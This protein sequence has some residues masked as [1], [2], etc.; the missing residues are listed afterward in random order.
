MLPER[1]PSSAT[2]QTGASGRSF[3]V[4]RWKIKHGAVDV[5]GIGDQAILAQ[6]CLSLICSVQCPGSVVI[7]TF[8]AIRELR[9]AGITVAGGFH[10]PM[11]K[12]CLEF[13]LRGE[14]PVI[15]VQAKGLGRLR[16]P[17]PWRAP[18]DAGRLL[19]LAPFDDD[20]GR[21]T[22]AHAQTRN[23]VITAL[24]AAVLIPHASPGGKA[25]TVARSVLQRGQA[26]FTFDD[27]ENKGL[28]QLGAHPYNVDEIKYLITAA[29]LPNPVAL[30]R[31]HHENS[32]THSARS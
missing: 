7:K 28:F 23:E 2:V 3:G 1:T 12:E 17:E 21:T 18:I 5:H 9:D 32:S 30:S 4:A 14:Q 25:E 24:A 16:L 27:D 10:S 20:V 15:A 8:D 29:P 19:I 13:L 6:K 31:Q 26:L 11:E 22:K